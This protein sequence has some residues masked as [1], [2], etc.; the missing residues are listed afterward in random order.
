MSSSE[1]F[2]SIF[3][4]IQDLRPTSLAYEVHTL[5]AN[6]LNESNGSPRLI[7]G[8][9]SLLIEG[10]SIS[11]A[12]NWD[13]QHCEITLTDLASYLV[14]PEQDGTIKIGSL[15]YEEGG[16][17]KG[18]IQVKPAI[19]RDIL[20]YFRF[21]LIIDESGQRK[22]NIVLRLDISRSATKRID[23]DKYAIYRLSLEDS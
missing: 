4:Q 11:S 1:Q 10:G 19:L 2:Q 17:I 3:I 13:K 23:G 16:G 20:D 12:D 7:Q 21:P 5:P 15:G 18:V 14:A 22:G 9:Y 8:C 6:K